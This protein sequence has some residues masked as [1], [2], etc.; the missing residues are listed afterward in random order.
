[1]LILAATTNTKIVAKSEGGLLGLTPDMAAAIHAYTQES[2]F[3]K[4]LNAL[5]RSRAREELKPFFPYMKLFLSAMHRLPPVKC[6]LYV[7]NALA[8]ADA[9]AD[10]DADDTNVDT[11]RHV[12]R[13]PQAACKDRV[14]VDGP[15]LHAPLAA[16]DD[17]LLLHKPLIQQV[18]LHWERISESRRGGEKGR[19]EG[20]EGESEEREGA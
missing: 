1:M 5:L 15:V 7:I 16:P 14:L 17:L 2:K 10:A 18:H 9:D 20:E 8:H 13:V 19:T 4:K 6:T 3:Y 12:A 11:D